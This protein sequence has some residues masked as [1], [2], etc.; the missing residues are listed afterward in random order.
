MTKM[1]EVFDNGYMLA[2]SGYEEEGLVVDKFRKIPLS[3]ITPMYN[4]RI[5]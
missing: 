5:L 3:K 2:M 1:K 4:G